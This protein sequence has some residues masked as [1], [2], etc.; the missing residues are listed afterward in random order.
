M[1]RHRSPR[2]PAGG[3]HVASIGPK[4]AG[5]SDAGSPL[6]VFD[7][8]RERIGQVIGIDRQT[9]PDLD[10]DIVAMIPG[11]GVRE[12][13]CC[14]RRVR[15]DGARRE[16]LRRRGLQA[17]PVDALAV[18]DELLLNL[19]DA[20][21]HGNGRHCRP[22]GAWVFART[23]TSVFGFAQ[24]RS[25]SNREAGFPRGAKYSGARMEA[26]ASSASGGGRRIRR[27]NVALT[28]TIH[29]WTPSLSRVQLR[30]A[31]NAVRLRRLHMG[32]SV[33]RSTRES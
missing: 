21:A 25:E 4:P 2:A 32:L 29:Q 18:H 27:S 28:A 24:S 23:R 10:S 9:S 5:P 22:P 8:M 16:R 12:D 3:S 6:C 26:A 20:E 19:P 7:R 30:S 1:G 11:I 33:A 15:P 31:A 14:R 13:P 17:G